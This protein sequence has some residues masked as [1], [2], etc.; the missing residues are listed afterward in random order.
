MA[1]IEK[2][3]GRE[4]GGYTRLFGI[5]ELGHL[6]SRVQAT[7]ISSGT[8]LETLIWDRCKQIDD[9]DKFIT[10]YLHKKEAGI[11]VARKNQIKKSERVNSKYEPDFIAFDLM[12]KTCYV[13]EVKD[14]DAFD[15]KK[16]SG[17]HKTLKD[18]TNDISSALPY[19]FRI[20]LCSFNATDK[21]EMYHGLKRKFSK[22]ELM[23]G[24]ELCV[25]FDIDYSEIVKIRTSE[26][27]NN[28][29]YFINNL[30]KIEPIKAMIAKRLSKSKED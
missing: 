10:E 7:V 12:T 1:L 15:T 16:A 3:K 20:F 17:E 21:D 8:E 25:L 26:P 19:S 18:F 4:D 24:Q 9:L 27:Q 13:I 30:V 5:K 11:W 29:D 2:M 14:G 6:I 23:T 28:L 22:D